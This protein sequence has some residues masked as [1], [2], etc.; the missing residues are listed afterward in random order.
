LTIAPYYAYDAR[1]GAILGD[2]KP[3]TR[4]SK[5]VLALE[6]SSF[7]GDAVKR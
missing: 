6:V 4:T 3:P 2:M 1:F 5:A 7:F